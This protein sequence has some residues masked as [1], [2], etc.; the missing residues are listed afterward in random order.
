MNIEYRGPKETF[1]EDESGQHKIEVKIDGEVIGGAEIDYYSKPFPLYQ[2]TDLWVD[3]KEKGKGYA[4]KIMDEVE[5]MLKRKKRPGVLVDAIS[6]GD[7][8]V[9]MYQRRGWEEV[10]TMPT[11]LVF[12][13]KNKE[14]MK[15]LV[16]YEQRYTDMIER[17][18]FDSSLLDDGSE[19]FAN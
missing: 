10:P 16:G 6:P 12:N 4:S 5:T 9:G 17:E 1:A 11:L 18:G 7:P 3:Y 14:M 15:D 19:D 8:E 2:I 13:L